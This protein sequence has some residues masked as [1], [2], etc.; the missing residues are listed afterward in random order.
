MASIFF[1]DGFEV[2]DFDAVGFGGGGAVVDV[3]FESARVGCFFEFS[4]DGFGGGHGGGWA[5]VKPCDL[6]QWFGVGVGVKCLS[7]L[8]GIRVG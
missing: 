8:I 6:F 4:E 7:F 5:G 2:R 3:G 1:S